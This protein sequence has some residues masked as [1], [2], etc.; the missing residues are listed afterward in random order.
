MTR[1]KVRVRRASTEP[2]PEEAQK[3]D[4]E[5]APRGRSR[6]PRAFGEDAAAPVSRRSRRSRSTFEPEE[7]SETE[8]VQSEIAEPEAAPDDEEEPVQPVRRSR[9]VRR[10]V[11]EPV[12]EKPAPPE[13]TQEELSPAEKLEEVVAEG[14]EEEPPTRKRRVSRSRPSAKPAAEEKPPVEE[15]VTEPEQELEE[16]EPAQ[17][18]RR[19]TRRSALPKPEPTPEA[20]PLPEKPQT[21][22]EEEEED[23]DEEAESEEASLPMQ[24]TE[25]EISNAILA[26]LAVGKS[27]NIMKIGTRYVISEG[28]EMTQVSKRSTYAMTKDEME[29]IA[30]T[31][32]YVE[33]SKWWPKLTWE[34]KVAEAEKKKVS[35]DRHDDAQVDNIRCTVAMRKKMGVRKWKAP[36]KTRRAKEDL[37]KKGIRAD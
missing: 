36:Y 26:V 8:Q 12:E 29:A 37:W 7:D 22:E 5:E 34:E 17:P 30:M 1:R 14:V 27:I 23:W 33:F 25:N 11:A 24:A 16:P 18:T 32:E 2:A 10:S 3:E 35:W 28:Q 21:P 9:R 6:T 4:V 31:A 13:V 15:P 20:K 19:R